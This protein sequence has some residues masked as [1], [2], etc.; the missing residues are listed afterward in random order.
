MACLKI[1]AFGQ[2]FLDFRANRTARTPATQ[3][4]K[5]FPRSLFTL[6]CSA[7]LK[8][9]RKRFSRAFA[10]LSWLR[11]N[12]GFASEPLSDSNAISAPCEILGQ[13]CGREYVR[14]RERPLA[15]R[16]DPD[17]WVG[18]RRAGDAFRSRTAST[19]LLVAPT[20]NPHLET[21]RLY[22]AAC[23]RCM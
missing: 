15:G 18:V 9:K 8:K 16:E 6:Q 11:C 2:S 10:G 22:C 21:A 23:G 14:C 13:G 4:K 5:I 17:M 12:I 3:W 19:P 1:R 20:W 7:A